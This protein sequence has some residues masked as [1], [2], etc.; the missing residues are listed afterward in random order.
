M[1]TKSLDRQITF[2]IPKRDWDRL[3][4]A[5]GPFGKVAPLLRFLIEEYLKKAE[6]KGHAA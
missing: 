5:V 4:K 2:K 6:A 1:K 3:I